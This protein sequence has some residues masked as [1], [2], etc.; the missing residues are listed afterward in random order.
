[1]HTD[2]GVIIRT[3][4]MVRVNGVHGFGFVKEIIWC[5]G[6]NKCV[7]LVLLTLHGSDKEAELMALCP[8]DC[9]L[10]HSEKS[11]SKKVYAHADEHE[12]Y[13]LEMAA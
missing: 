7:F 12:F 13:A 11:T 4:N 9:S 1:M 10:Y 5:A 2:K 3:G 6:S 8:S